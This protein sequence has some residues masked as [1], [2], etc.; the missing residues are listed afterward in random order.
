[1]SN[2]TLAFWLRSLLTCF[3]FFCLLSHLNPTYG[4][5][6]Q[7]KYQSTN[8]T[9][10][11]N[12][13]PPITIIP[14]NTYNRTTLQNTV[15]PIVIP[16]NNTYNRTQPSSNPSLTSINPPTLP[17]L[18]N[19]LRTNSTNSTRLLE[20]PPSPKI[21]TKT[22]GIPPP[23]LLPNKTIASNSSATSPAPSVYPLLNDPKN[24]KPNFNASHSKCPAQPLVPDTWRNLKIDDYLKN[25]PGGKTLN[26]IDY[27][28]SV[29][30][31]NFICG[32]GQKCNI[33]QPCF[34]V[35]GLDWYVLFA[36]QQWNTY[37]NNFFLAV[38]YALAM[39]Q[40]SISALLASIFPAVDQS[41]AKQFKAN[42]AINAGLTEV[43]GTIMMDIMVLFA[44]AMGPLGWALNVLNFMIAAGM[45][46]AA[47][48][49]KLPDTPIQDGFGAWS[50]TAY[51]ISKYEELS[52][53]TLAKNAKKFLEAGIST[54][55]GLYGTMKNGS[56]LSPATLLTIP[57]IEDNIRNVSLALSLNLIFH[58]LNAFITVGSDECTDKGKNGAWAQDDVLSYCDKPGGTMF[59]IIR[60]VDGKS[61]N[62]L[63]N[64]NVI[65]EEYGYSTE[66]ITQVSLKCQET[67]GGFS[68]NP[69]TNGSFPQD[70]TSDC[71]FNL[72]VCFCQKPEIHHKIHEKKWT[73]AKACKEVGGLPL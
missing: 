23:P 25:Y 44:S 46:F 49:I 55:E 20:I 4:F 30:A 1:M 43:T 40:S 32:I 6:L 69:Y 70:V 65:S 31:S 13:V 38:G 8:Q 58:S 67:H 57:E 11:Q 15:P 29:N 48:A 41:P 60:Y 62:D 73:V 54:E 5:T 24:K 53:D 22:I 71:V 16:P 35:E 68:F 27:A 37:M 50:N 34:P 28:T 26:L 10:L 59:N 63:P 66:L 56:F 9:T 52:H 7:P 72:P 3:I 2:R 36:V 21:P 42:F 12:T 14:N 17:Q 47:F 39:V 45:G 61:G 33:G 64:A 19:T 18:N 51:F